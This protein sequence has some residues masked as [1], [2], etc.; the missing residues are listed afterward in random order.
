MRVSVPLL[1]VQ[2]RGPLQRVLD[3]AQGL[4]DRVVQL[5]SNAPA[6]ALLCLDQLL[7][8]QRKLVARLT[9]GVLRRLAPQDFVL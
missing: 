2:H 6:L 4:P 9:Q 3:G 8:Q 7:R 5:L 1:A